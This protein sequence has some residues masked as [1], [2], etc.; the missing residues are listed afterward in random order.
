MPVEAHDNDTFALYRR[1][2]LPDGRYV[3]T[4]RVVISAIDGKII[5]AFP[6]TGG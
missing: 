2:F 6:Q 4:T 1:I 3:C 5:T